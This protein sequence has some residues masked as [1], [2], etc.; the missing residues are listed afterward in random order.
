M[1]FGAILYRWTT[2]FRRRHWPLVS[3]DEE[4]PLRSELFS[5]DQMAQHGH[6]LAASHQLAT[7]RAP[8]LLLARLAENEAAMVGVCAL[9][10][11]EA[12]AKRRITPA[13]EWLLDNFYLIEE[14]IRTAERHLPK[15]Y[16]RV[17]PR[18]ARGQSPGRPPV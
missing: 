7:G 1:K 9:L 5:A 10:T 8:D 18:L 13:G 16:S 2:A 12:T 17:Q 14:H 3:R 4:P 6:A 15:G 11:A